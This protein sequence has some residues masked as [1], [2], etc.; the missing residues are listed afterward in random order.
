MKCEVLWAIERECIGCA[1]PRRH[2]L[3]LP[4]FSAC[5]KPGDVTLS[6]PDDA[7]HAGFDPASNPVG[8]TAWVPHGLAEQKGKS[9]DHAYLEAKSGPC[10]A[11]SSQRKRKKGI[12]SV[13]ARMP[14]KI[15]EFD[16]LV[17]FEFLC[18]RLDADGQRTLRETL[19]IEQA[20]IAPVARV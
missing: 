17:V 19:K 2:G 8:L 15:T 12:H 10:G 16:C 4:A 6:E 1:I 14:W 18:G 13:V 3:H 9:G 7:S 5:P 11:M 20:R